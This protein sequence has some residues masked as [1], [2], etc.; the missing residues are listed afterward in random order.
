[1]P[2]D[3]LTRRSPLGVQVSVDDIRRKEAEWRGV[4]MQ[5]PTPVHYD[6]ITE[7]WTVPHTH[8]AVHP[9]LKHH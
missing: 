2:L 6:D 5:S 9:W 8:C 1:M 4:F 3:A 7:V